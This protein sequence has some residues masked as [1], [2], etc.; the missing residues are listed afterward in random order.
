V[1][2][3]DRGAASS[4]ARNPYEGIELDRAEGITTATRE[5]PSGARHGGGGKF[6]LDD[7]DRDP[8]TVSEKFDTGDDGRHLP[9]GSVYQHA[10]AAWYAHEGDM[11]TDPVSGR[12][13]AV[14]TRS[15]E[16]PAE[17]EPDE[18]AVT[19]R[20]SRYEAG[21]G[22]GDDYSPYY[23][24]DL[25]V[26]PLDEDGSI[27]WNRTPPRSLSLKLE[28]QYEGL[29]YPDGNEFRLPHGE[30]TLVRVQTTW[31]EQTEE[32]LERAAH[33]LGHALD[34]GV[35]Q[36]DL[37]TESAAFSKA[38]VH[39]RLTEEVEGDV[40]HTIRQSA[41]LL[42]KHDADVKTTGV[43]EDS[44]WLEAKIRTEGW[45]QLGFPRLDAP[46]LIKLYYPDD[47]DSVEYPMDQPK[48]EVALDGKETVVDEETGRTTQ[49]MVPWGRWDE[50]MAVLEEILLSHLTWADVSAADLVADDYSDGPQ[51]PRTQWR[52]PEGRRHWLR[53]H[54]ES[55]VPA[56]YREATRTRTDLVLDILDVV[57]RRGEATY[58]D[59]VQ[60]TGAAK[61][62]IREHVR[63]LDEEIGD[64]SPGLLS[65]SRGAKTLVAYSSRFLEDLGEN[66]I[67]SIQ[68]DRDELTEDRSE[69]ADER[70]QDHLEVLGLS[71][72]DA[73][74]LVEAV[75][76]EYVYSRD[77]LRAVDALEDLA[78]I[79]E[80]LGLDIA[81]TTSTSE[82]KKSETAEPSASEVAE[83]DA[84][85]AVPI[86]GE[87]LGY[88]LE[89]GRI[90]EDHVRI[91][92][93]PYP[94]L[95]D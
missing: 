66:A 51:N 26:Q 73:A 35:R 22:E 61:R 10:R 43:H 11:V 41:E 82:C 2:R 3:S 91:R 54:Y 48:L 50:V 27:A 47:P 89:E 56:L 59:L 17:D 44:R 36:R 25:T 6:V 71:S 90:D 79:V 52:H 69:R 29:V 87:T 7:V 65:R 30:G 95:A 1:S 42:A 33:L 5:L 18:Y 45:E 64:D 63:R 38:E 92:T 84:F 58:D 12:D 67:D 72:S 28:P 80:D 93:D 70:V 81:L 15:Y 85:G 94:R 46:I 78:P 60:E 9:D 76:D 20:S 62:T 37:V 8:N 32:F 57:R 13:Y 55:L 19:L 49:R 75:R 83:W 86:D 4:R 14:L 16:H 39:H 21:T 68:A 74:V 24:Y 34:Y 31:V 77:D 40:T 53:K 23:K 88:A